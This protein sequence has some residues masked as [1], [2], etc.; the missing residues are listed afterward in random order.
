MVQQLLKGCEGWRGWFGAALK[1]K[2]SGFKIIPGHSLS[3][4]DMS[5]NSHSL[6]PDQPGVLK[7]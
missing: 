5:L 6:Y 2:D 1:N 3:F 4:A 7:P